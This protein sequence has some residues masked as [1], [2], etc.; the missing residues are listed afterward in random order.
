MSHVKCLRLL[1]PVVI[2]CILLSVALARP[3]PHHRSAAL[4]SQP[5]LLPSGIWYDP[6]AGLSR[7]DDQFISAF[8]AFPASNMSIRAASSKPGTT[9]L[10]DQDLLRQ[11]NLH[12]PGD[13]L[14]LPVLS[15]Q[16]DLDKVAA[17]RQAPLVIKGS[18]M[19]FHVTYSSGTPSIVKSSFEYSLKSWANTFPCPVPIRLRLEWQ[20][21]GGATLGATTTPFFIPGDAQ[22]ADR[23]DDGTMYGSVLAASLEGKDF[24][25]E[26]EFHIIMTFNSRA[27]W[28]YDTDS[29][30][31]YNKWDLATT[32]LHEQC[33]GLF[34]TG[35]VQA[36]TTQRLASFSSGSGKPARFDRFL[37]ASSGAG[38]AESCNDPSKFYNALTNNGLRFLDPGNDRANFGLY[39]PNPYEAGSSTYHNDPS[40]LNEDCRKLGIS[41]NDCSDLMT[42]KLPPGYTQR[43]I[44]VPVM[45]IMNSMLSGSDG[46][47]DGNCDIDSGSVS[48]ASDGS[49]RGGTGS[50]GSSGFTLPLWAII[51]ISAIGAVG[52]VALLIALFTSF[53]RGR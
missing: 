10:S 29:N 31:P 21:I 1:L 48:S 37:A 43:S 46:L 24:V 42:Q 33:H 18:K 15:H 27:L 30:A 23:L 28:H 12:V 41:S 34:F 19:T 7:E 32:A 16:V 8:S 51:T 4:K 35:V 53:A 5:L 38:I 6:I 50:S 45:L 39:S 2:S 49:A 47:G 11:M 9:Y 26:S 3:V 20:E 52:A 40:R 13:Q 25:P 14:R 36:S 22:N 17:V 44:G